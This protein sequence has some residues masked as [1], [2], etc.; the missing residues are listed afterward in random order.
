MGTESKSAASAVKNRAERV[1]RELDLGDRG[2]VVV[3][4]F[5]VS[6]E[7]SI[8]ARP[9]VRYVETET[10]FS[11][12]GHEVE[13]QSSV[14]RVD[15]ERQVTPWG[16]DRIG[17][18]TVHDEGVTGKETHVAIIDTGIDSDHPDLKANLG[19]GYAT[20]PCDDGCRRDWDDDHSHG[21]HC[22]GIAGAV[23]NS[24]G[25]VGVCPDTT[26]HGVKVISASGSGSAS[27]I[28]DGLVWVA[29]QGYDVAS[30]SLGS[31][32]SSEIIH[33]AVKY[34]TDKGVVVVAAAGNEEPDEKSVHYPAAYPE[35]IAVG[36]TDDDDDLADFSLT[37]DAVEIVAPGVRIPSTVIDGD[38]KYYSGTSMAT[39]HVTGAVA[40]LKAAGYSADE[41]RGRLAS[42]TEDLG[43]DDDEQGNGLL[44][45]DA[46][47]GEGS[48]GGDDGDT[49]DGFAVSTG[50]ATDVEKTSATITGSL[51]SL[52]EQSAATVGFEY[53]DVDDEDGTK[54][55]VDVGERSETGAFETTLDGL[56]S[57][58]T[59]AFVAF[60][61]AGGERVTGRQ[62]DFTTGANP[63]DLFSIETG[64]PEDVEEDEADLVGYVTSVDGRV[65]EVV[66]VFDCWEKGDKSGTLRR[67]EA[68]DTDDPDDFDEEVEDLEPDTTYVYVAVGISDDVEV[69]G[70]PVEF[71]TQGCDD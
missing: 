7:P 57:D 30:L 34:A 51:D 11:V 19:E 68:G 9:G 25:V 55:T 26:L 4:D 64:E 67:V 10:E 27:S 8:Q 33:D 60:A 59:Y 17:A 22:A 21:T 49:G 29:D 36:A 37:G 53:W 56:S 6:T 5:P 20:V 35:A 40:T 13:G 15:V 63:T 50:G 28:A 52:G 45:V 48:D 46:A 44:N 65:E 69:R 43:M 54:E 42:T 2:Y 70:E 47:V 58:T 14:E 12:L 62:T 3:G 32:S 18:D 23:S 16:V 38:Y 24:G 66:T 1:V 61:V 41:I 31:T 71:E 39:P